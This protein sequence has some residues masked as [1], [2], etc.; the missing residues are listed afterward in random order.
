MNGTCEMIQVSTDGERT[1][2]TECGKPAT[3]RSYSYLCCA[4]CARFMEWEGIDVQPLG[5]SVRRTE[6]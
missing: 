3:H 1:Q 6:P 4:D 5:E 2:E